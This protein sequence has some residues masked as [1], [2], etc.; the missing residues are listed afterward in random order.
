[1]GRWRYYVIL[2]L[3]VIINLYTHDVAIDVWLTSLHLHRRTVLWN[4]YKEVYPQFIK[5][6]GDIMNVVPEKIRKRNY[7]I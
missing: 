5:S 3:H 6:P 2:I 7:M 1:M 4:A